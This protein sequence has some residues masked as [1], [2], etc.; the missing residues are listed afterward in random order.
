MYYKSPSNSQQNVLNSSEYMCLRVFSISLFIRRPSPPFWSRCFRRPTLVN[1]SRRHAAVLLSAKETGCLQANEKHWLFRPMEGKCPAW[2][3]PG[4]HWK[5][6]SFEAY[7]DQEGT[8]LLK[9]S[10]WSWAPFLPLVH[11][12]IFPAVYWGKEELPY[13]K[14]LGLLFV[15]FLQ[16]TKKIGSEYM[17]SKLFTSQ[18]IILHS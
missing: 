12:R 3:D 17:K 8:K 16:S 4:F 6:W 9:G 2:K 10:T 5:L 14:E 1:L 13:P 15:C 11:L 7:K 18:T